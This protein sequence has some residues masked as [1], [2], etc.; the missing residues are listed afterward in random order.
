MRIES[1]VHVALV[2]PVRGGRRAH[3]AVLRG[4]ASPTTTTRRPTSSTTSTT[5]AGRGPVPL[6]QPPRGVDRGAR[7]AGSS[8]PATRAAGCMGSTT[9]QLVGK[10][11]TFEPVALPDIQAEPEVARDRG[12]VRADAGGARRS[13]RPRRVRHPPFVQLKPP[14]RVD[15]ARRSRSTPTARADFE[16]VGASP[17]PRHWVYDADGEPRGQG[18]PHRLQGVVPAGVRQAHA[19]GRRG[20]AGVRHR[21]R[22][23]ARARA[24]DHDHA[25]RREARDPQGE[26]GRGARRA[27]RAGRRAVPA[28]RRRALGRGRRR[29]ARR[30]RARRDARRAGACSRAARARRRCARATKCRIA[31]A[32]ESRSTAPH[33]RS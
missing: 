31:V 27:G 7:T 29:A 32:P 30:A 17:F 5:L 20:L 10:Q 4:R 26:G 14:D 25:R 18:R 21:G 16:L 15:D 22:D 19:V 8:T 12:A 13:P 6:R 2:D 9:V 1:S 3:Q 11:R 23:R 33:S 28:A 24:V